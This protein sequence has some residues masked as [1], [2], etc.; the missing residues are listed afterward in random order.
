MF[1]KKS[2][3]KLKG[4]MEVIQKQLVETKNERINTLKE[5]KRFFKEFE[6]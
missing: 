6:R 2:H 4:E 1:E 5:V 3:D